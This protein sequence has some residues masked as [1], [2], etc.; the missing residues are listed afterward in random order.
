M[1]G[2]VRLKNIGPSDNRALNKKN[3]IRRE[4]IREST[5]F[6]DQAVAQGKS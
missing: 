4:T 2:I 3:I 6:E 1:V 5:A